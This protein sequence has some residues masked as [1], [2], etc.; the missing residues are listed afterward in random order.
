MS[1]GKLAAASSMVSC[2]ILGREEGGTE[3]QRETERGLYLIQRHT[4]RLKI[5]E[6]DTISFSSTTGMYIIVIVKQH[7]KVWQNIGT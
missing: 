1:H 5:L 2:P 4:V 7:D 6:I 3:R